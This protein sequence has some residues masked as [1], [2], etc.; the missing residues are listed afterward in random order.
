MTQEVEGDFVNGS[1]TNAQNT[2]RDDS[3][4]LISVQ[5]DQSVMKY[6]C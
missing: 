5:N 6:E 3:S 1:V 4:P 2:E